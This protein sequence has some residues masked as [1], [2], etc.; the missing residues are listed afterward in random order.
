MTKLGA[1]LA[2]LFEYARD[3]F[4]PSSRPSNDAV[5]GAAVGAA[6]QLCRRSQEFEIRAGE[7]GQDSAGGETFSKHPMQATGCGRYNP[8]GLDRGAMGI[9]PGVARRGEFPWLVAVL[10]RRDGLTRYIGGGSLIAANVVL[11]AFHILSGTVEDD[12]L[13]RAGEWNVS[14]TAEMPGHVDLGVEKVILHDQYNSFSGENDIALLILKASF[15]VQ[16]N[17]GTLC[18]PPA[19]RSFVGRRCF[20]NGWGPREAH[21]EDYPIVPKKVDVNMIEKSLCQERWGRRVPP[22]EVC[23]ESPPI[24]RRAARVTAAR[25]SCVPCPRIPLASSRQEL[26]PLAPAAAPIPPRAST[27]TCPRCVAGSTTIYR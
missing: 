12:L 10:D 1:E 11:T 21:S 25:R 27:P 20:F 19:N 23:A 9:V 26:S 14:S 4:S 16:P 24:A 5:L 18:L 17:I 3:Q 22:N 8:N 7:S 15:P 2:E 6:D 13:V